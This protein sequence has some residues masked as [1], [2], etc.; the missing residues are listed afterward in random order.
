MSLVVLLSDCGHADP[1]VAEM[2][3]ALLRCGP[4]GLVLVDATHEIPFG[5]VAAGRWILSQLWGQFPEGAI[6]LAVVDPGAGT[7]R[8]AIAAHADG[9]WFVGPGNGL[10]SF[11]RPGGQPRV[12]RL[13]RATPPPGR[14]A[15]TTFAGRDVF[16]PAAAHLAGGGD[17]DGVGAAGVAA[18]LGPLAE[19]DGS[20]RVVWVDRFGNLITDLT[21]GSRAGQALAAGGDVLIGGVRVSGPRDQYDGAPAGAPFWYWGSCDTLEVAIA[22]ASAA[23]ALEAEPGLVISPAAS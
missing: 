13:N 19:A 4:A 15:S 5:D 11:L 14:R 7:A 10:A 2:K 3:A 21:R 18:D 6:F 16:A 12:W 22:G 20:P 23:V 1:Y 8:P 17:P 9:C